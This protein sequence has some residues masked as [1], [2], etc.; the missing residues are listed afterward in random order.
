[1]IRPLVFLLLS[2]C[3]IG[4]TDEPPPSWDYLPTAYAEASGEV[5]ARGEY[6]R[7]N[8]I[9]AT[10]RAWGDKITARFAP[11][12]PYLVIR[13][14]GGVVVEPLFPEETDLANEDI[15]SGR[16]VLIGVTPMPT[17]SIKRMQAAPAPE[18]FPPVEN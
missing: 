11:F 16:V 17:G 12:P 15:A 14:S 1:M 6:P 4:S 10:F 7:G 8:P 9:T 5:L 18:S 3:A 13:G 2:G